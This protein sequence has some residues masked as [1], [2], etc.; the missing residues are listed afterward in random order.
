MS[1][2]YYPATEPRVHA[3]TLVI[4]DGPTSVTS[5][6][7]DALEQSGHR[8]V[9]FVLGCN[10][11]GNEAVLVDAI[12]RGFALGNHS[13]LHPHFSE[14]DV[15]VARDEIVRTDAMIDA[16]Y[17]TAGV[18]RQGRW[19]RFPY[20]DTGGDKHNAFQLLLA[21]LGFT[22]PDAVRVRLS[23]A[24][25]ARY[26]WPTTVS[27]RDWALPS[28]K[29]FR[30]S[31]ANAVSGDV[32]EYHDKIETV[33]PY[34]DTLVAALGTRRLRAVIP[35]TTVK[36]AVLVSWW[37]DSLGGMERHICETACALVGAGV[38]VDYLSEMP[39]A[40]SNV[41]RQ[42]ME[43]SG[44]RVHSEMPLPKP[45]A[46]LR[47]LLAA[48]G[49]LPVAR[50]AWRTIKRLSRTSA[51]DQI[52]PPTAGSTPLSTA[53]N[54]ES[55]VAS[56]SAEE[57]GS[58]ARGNETFLAALEALFQS[59]NR[60][61][62]L[63]VHG[64]RLGQ[65]YII[66]WAQAR[67]I[68]TMYTEHVTISEFG[69]PFRPESPATMMKA[70]L[71]ACVSAHARESLLSV[72]PASRPVEISNHL[73]RAFARPV[74][75]ASHPFDWVCV[76]R[77]NHNKGIDVLLRAFA[78]C[79]QRD[80]RFKLEI[81]GDGSERAELE[82]L[83]HEL[84]IASRVT[85][86]GLVVGLPLT[87]SLQRAGG[88]VL[89]S[90]SEAMPVSIIEAM[91]HGKAIVATTVGGIP[92]LLTNGVNALLVL[93]DDVQALANAMYQMSTQDDLRASIEAACAAH[94]A[95]LP[96]HEGAVVQSLLEMY[97]NT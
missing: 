87:T 64:I 79:V 74:H 23:K 52:A 16:L 85:F 33:A 56:T 42:Q 43:Q 15:D 28:Q 19:F 63:H 8:A 31:L 88:V 84:G 51:S 96:Y 44:V 10:I 38:A 1:D 45:G 9:L 60:P 68:R 27:T 14:I 29:D 48:T 82:A 49:M 34:V 83:A 22:V 66:E 69:G 39:L 50:V 77:L 26:D 3:V 6:L 59:E 78:Q 2:T 95:T 72:L 81:L 55:V 93:P 32:I 57:D 7:I 37:L 92:E 86:S 47:T 61:D 53:T 5:A 90:R 18:G 36:R 75:F 46:Q 62:V 11:P 97:A 17:T 35:A 12:R 80:V 24:D 58:R 40:E 89:S 76:A 25:H 21:E 73:V 65:S 67:G 91:A 70:D 13:F 20:L 4:D 54:S 41:Y 94:F 71:L 30:A